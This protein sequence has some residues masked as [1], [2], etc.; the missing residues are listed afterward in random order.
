MPIPVV[1]YGPIDVTASFNQSNISTFGTLET[2]ELTPV[3]QEDFVYGL[4]TQQWSTAVVSGAGAAVDTNASRLRI[5]SG[6]NASG[7]A[8]I[9]SRHFIRYRP[10][11][12][13]VARFTMIFTAGSASNVQLLGV[14]SIASNAPYDGYFF[15]FNGTAFGI[16]R[17]AAGTPT[18]VA[19]T[20]WNGDQC[21]GGSSQFGTLDPT[22]GNVA[23]IKYP[24]LGYGS[25]EFFL[26]S[27]MTGRWV[28]CHTI[29]Y[30]NA[31]TAVQ[32]TNPTMQFIGFTLNSGNTSNK[33]MYCGSLGIFISGVRSFVNDPEWAI[34]NSKTNPTVETNIIGLLNCLSY[35]GVVNKGLI[36]LRSLSSVTTGG[37]TPYGI[38]RLK[39]NPTIGGTPAYAP[40]SG[41]TADNGVTITNGNSITSVDTAGTTI[42]GGTLI[43]NTVVGQNAPIF[44]DLTPFDLFVAPGEVLSITGF[45][46][47]NAVMSVA[48][49]W[50]EDI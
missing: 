40:I 19:Q 30:P 27:P 6:T 11:Q 13:Q 48:V 17:Y 2:A 29:Q 3:V 23:M 10:G 41:S 22:K 21:N 1:T 45:V 50:S 43:F 15:G 26:L 46:S 4:N 44:C 37:G 12:G 14:G 7:Y 38:I 49:N 47:A 31:F 25:I 8:Y 24:Y 34:D 16:V 20:S 5:Q 39:I 9:M 42:A 35:N 32:V 36:R 18:W 28:L 33:I